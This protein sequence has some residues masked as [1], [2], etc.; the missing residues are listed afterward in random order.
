MTDQAPSIIRKRGEAARASLQE[1]FFDL[2]IVAALAQMS[3]HLASNVTVTGVIGTVLPLLAVWWIWCVT[4]MMTDVF[5]PDRI[6]VQ[7]ALVLSMVGTVLMA[8]IMPGAVGPQALIFASVYVTIHNGRQVI[9]LGAL[10]GGAARQR[11]GRYLFWFAGAA[12]A[13]IIGGLVHGT[14]RYVLWGLGLFIDYL[15]YAIRHP[16]PRYGRLPK[17]TYERRGI[18]LSE[19]FQQIMIVGLGDLVL[20][21]TLEVSR[22]QFSAPRVIAFLVTFVQ[23]AILWQIYVSR[24]GAVIPMLNEHRPA[25]L[26]RWALYTHLLMIAGIVTMAAAAEMIIRAPAGPAPGPSVMVFFAGPLLFLIGRAAFE[27]EVFKRV[28]WSRVAFMLVLVA[29]A[30]VMVGGSPVLVQA[31]AT[32][33]LLCV[34]ISDAVR[35]HL[36]NRG[37]T[38]ALSRDP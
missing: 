36:V 23:T 30:P 3:R 10:R 37:T 16:V 28:S 8:A 15:G 2:A 7:A 1:L 17:N 29:L 18:H 4:A 31:T 9:L 24:A 25:R 34:A 6:P 13:W 35:T 11:A 12:P 27:F 33:V 26:V 19:R 32:A 22:D 20:V 14:A 5:D 21:P 38:R